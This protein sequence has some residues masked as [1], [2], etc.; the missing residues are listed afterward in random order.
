[1][2]QIT[3]ETFVSQ[4]IYQNNTLSCCDAPAVI[5]NVDGFPVCSNCGCVLSSTT[6]D[7]NTRRA[8]TQDEQRKRVHTEPSWRIFGN[9][10]CIDINISTKPMYRRLN[11]I[12]CSY[13]NGFERNLAQA[14]PK[15]YKIA[16][17]L[18]LPN[19]IVETAR[20]IYAIAV[21]QRYTLGRSISD[22]T[23]ASLYAAVRVH[24]S[25]YILEDFLQYAER[26]ARAIHQALRMVVS[27]IL[28]ILHLQYHPITVEHIIQRIGAE[29]QISQDIQRKAI[30]IYQAAKKKGLRI[31]GRDPRGFA[32]AALYIAGK[33]CKL[34]MTQGV[35]SSAI[36]VTEVTLRTCATLLLKQI[37][38]T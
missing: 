18:G 28:P 7:Y 3:M 29:L 23:I 31:N 11:K 17:D 38:L 26:S 15:L 24:Q 8:Y 9:R 34:P 20:S 16:N 32:V 30:A 1:M 12:H 25:F 19:Y 4:P 6:F 14:I 27:M 2:D 10:T 37:E 36:H 5:F 35:L 13:L 33:R 22:F 21:K